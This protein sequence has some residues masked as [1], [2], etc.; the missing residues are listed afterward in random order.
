MLLSKK[1][2]D[3]AFCFEYFKNLYLDKVLIL[4]DARCKREKF[5]YDL[6]RFGEMSQE[7][8]GNSKSATVMS[9]P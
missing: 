9:D 7:C 4:S 5:L 2:T 6:L 1:Y 8:N 3:D